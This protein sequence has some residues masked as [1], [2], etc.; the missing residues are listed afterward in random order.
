MALCSVPDPTP[1]AGW[2]GGAFWLEEER[3][4]CSL[5][6]RKMSTPTTGIAAAIHAQTARSNGANSEKMLIFSSGFRSRM[7]TL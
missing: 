4:A 1:L 7:P 6:S 3:S 5:L 2:P